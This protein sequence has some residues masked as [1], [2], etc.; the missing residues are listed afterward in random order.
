MRVGNW[1]ITGK[2]LY[3]II[4]GRTENWNYNSGFL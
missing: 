3:F 1:A 2:Q 4:K